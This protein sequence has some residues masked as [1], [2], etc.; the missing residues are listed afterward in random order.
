MTTALPYN[1]DDHGD[2]DSAMVETGLRFLRET[3]RHLRGSTIPALKALGLTTKQACA[4]C[5]EHH[6]ELRRA[7]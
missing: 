4:A 7:T 2:C 1:T 5:R 6:L 3:P